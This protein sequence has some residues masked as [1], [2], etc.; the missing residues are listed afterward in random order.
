MSHPVN[1]WRLI[2]KARAN[3]TVTRHPRGAG[4]LFVGLILGVVVGL[5][6]VAASQAPVELSVREFY[7]RGGTR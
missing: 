5:A 7:D 1:D 6:Y 4:I 2:H 3:K